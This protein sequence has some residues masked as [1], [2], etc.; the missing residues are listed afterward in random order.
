MIDAG[1]GNDRVRGTTAM[2]TLRGGTGN[3]VL[4]GGGGRDQFVF[5]E[6]DGDDVI[7]DFN[8]VADDRIR[9]EGVARATVSWSAVEDGVLVR[10]G[11]AGDTILLAGVPLPTLDWTD[12]A[13]A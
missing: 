5:R 3:D 8:A 1:A 12:F 13:F 6:G 11:S 7:M 2:D 4:W 10:Y 9:F